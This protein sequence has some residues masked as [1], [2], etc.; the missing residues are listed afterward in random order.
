MR[1][2]VVYHHQGPKSGEIWISPIVEELKAIALKLR[3]AGVGLM[4]FGIV[5]AGIIYLP[6]V[7]AQVRY[8]G[9]ETGVVQVE[10]ATP[11]SRLGPAL[12]DKPAWE[13]PDMNYSV[14]I[15]RIG[16]KANVIENVNA[17]DESAYL[18]ALQKGVAEVAGLAHPGKKGTTYM[19]SHSV[20]S[21]V[22]YARYNAVFYLLS[23][24]EV[25]D[26]IEVVYQGKLYRYEVALKEVLG[27]K[28][29]KYLVPQQ[30]EE[31]LVLQTCDPPGTSWSRLYVVARRI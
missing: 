28:D 26:R 9:I 22:S 11:I 18:A 27:P 19:F 23:K 12:E 21:P 10:K 6:L 4:I 25:G 13:V 3:W 5:G 20:S 24:M 31:K 17:A 1:K 15:P 30:S 14:Y 16:A 29:T 7:E 8:V 2:G